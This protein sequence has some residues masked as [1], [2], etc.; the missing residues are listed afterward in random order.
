MNVPKK[1][2]EVG[3]NIAQYAKTMIGFFFEKIL[4]CSFGQIEFSSNRLD[5]NLLLNRPFPLL[6]DGNGVKKIVEKIFFLQ[7]NPWTRRFQV[8]KP[9]I[10]PLGQKNGNSIARR[11]EK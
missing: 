3:K 2:P 7:K 1:T 5:R 6:N 11:P 9:Y 10:E 4:K 8:W